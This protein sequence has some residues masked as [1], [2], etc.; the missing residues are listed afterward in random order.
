MHN[1]TSELRYTNA[2]WPRENIESVLNKNDRLK[3]AYNVYRDECWAGVKRHPDDNL[4]LVF[5]H[6]AQMCKELWNFIIELCFRD[7]TLGPKLDKVVAIDCVNHGDSYLANTGKISATNMWTDI[8]RDITCVIRDL[9]MTGTTILVGHSM[10]GGASLYAAFFEPMLIDSI[11]T[12]DP[13][14]STSD[15]DSP[16]TIKSL[17]RTF[18]T[19]KAKKA[20]DRFESQAAYEQ[21]IRH[22]SLAA[23]FVP[24]CQDDYLAASA[25]KQSDGSYVFKTPQIQQLAIYLSGQFAFRDLAKILPSLYHEVLHV[26]P[27]LGNAKNAATFRNSLRH[28]TYGEIFGAGHL[29]PFEKP[30]ET[31]KAILPFILKRY[32]KGRSLA[33]ELSARSSWTPAQKQEYIEKTVESQLLA[34]HDGER[35]MYAKI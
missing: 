17:A 22:E 34:L 19:L 21:Y 20:L 2:H 26:Y 24:R 31:F 4:N 14:G 28:C 8:A 7:S 18:E 30:V 5:S 25:V 12:I 35:K 13:M 6:G 29:V 15:F 9:N 23:R 32:E 1:V 27:T 16:D 10:G 3:V 33:H 11:V